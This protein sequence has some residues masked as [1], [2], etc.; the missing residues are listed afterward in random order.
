MVRVMIILGPPVTC[1]SLVN[2]LRVCACVRRSPTWAN[3]CNNALVDGTIA[4]VQAEYHISDRCWSVYNVCFSV[5]FQSQWVSVFSKVRIACLV[6]ANSNICSIPG[7]GRVPVQ[8]AFEP[9]KDVS[10][11]EQRWKGYSAIIYKRKCTHLMQYI[12]FTLGLDWVRLWLGAK[13]AKVCPRFNNFDLTKTI[14]TSAT[15]D[16]EK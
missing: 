12:S 11:H 5:N 9:H 15:S 2:H 16:A 7:V 8:H 10:K 4:C 3:S 13:V 1:N 14:T 6:S